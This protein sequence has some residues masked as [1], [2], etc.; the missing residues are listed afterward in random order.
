[1]L[2]G[3]TSP[4]LDVSSV[5]MLVQLRADLDRDGVR[6]AL[7]H[8]IGQVRDVL[9]HAGEHGEPALF[10]TIDEAISALAH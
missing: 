6:F 3:E 4:S 5:E 9:S 7:A 8:G 2:D 10:A 1:M